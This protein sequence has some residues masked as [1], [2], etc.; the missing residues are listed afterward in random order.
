MQ[1]KHTPTTSS[2]NA[3]VTTVTAAEISEAYAKAAHSLVGVATASEQFVAACVTAGSM[4]RAKRDEIKTD[5]LRWLA[6]NCPEISQPTA[7]R[8]MTISARYSRGNSPQLPDRLSSIRALYDTLQE[9][10]EA[11]KKNDKAKAV[12]KDNAASAAK[13]IKNAISGFWEAVTKRPPKDWSED[14]R[15]GFL[16]D[17]AAREKIRDEHGW[18]LPADGDEI[19]GVMLVADSTW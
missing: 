18:Q 14:E 15:Y 4:L 12:K 10:A 6:E 3:A 1:D 19:P 13:A 9:T 16:T 5:W 7:S 8:L 11:G 17:L 2:G